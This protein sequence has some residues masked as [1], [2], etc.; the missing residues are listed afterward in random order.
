[1]DSDTFTSIASPP[2]S[3][4]KSLRD[5]ELLMRWDG[6]I[7]NTEGWY[8]P[9]GFAICEV[10]YAP[11]VAE[12]ART[13][14]GQ[15]YAKVTLHPNSS[16]PVPYS[17]RAAILR[18]IDSSLDQRDQNP[19]FATYKQIIPL[20]DIVAR[21]PATRSL[22]HALACQ[23]P[24]NH[25]RS[26]ISNTLDL[27]DIQADVTDALGL[28]GS[29]SLGATKNYHDCDLV[30]DATLKLNADVG[31]RI[32]ELV[33]RDAH[34]RIFEGGKSWRIRFFN[35]RRGLMCC[36][37]TYTQPD[38]DAPLRTFEEKLLRDDVVLE[39][40]VTDSTHSYYTPTILTVSSI[41]SNC[42]GLPADLQVVAYHTAS[43]GEFHAGDRLRASGALVIHTGSGSDSMSLCVIERDGL[44]NLSPPW[45]PYYQG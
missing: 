39:G 34:R 37:F 9:E 23:H 31:T 27:L 8:H 41:V 44:V 14:F 3:C 42:S 36:F 26:D 33:K 4:S 5:A 29:P 2:P 11:T 13:Y 7:L 35:D 6:L 10:M 19:W 17:Q 45:F 15:S 25:V 38:I 32:D 40:I 28:T 24:A 30:F 16:E 20:D 21:F 18:S 22:S 12:S 43:R 1:M